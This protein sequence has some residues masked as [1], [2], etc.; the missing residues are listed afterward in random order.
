MALIAVSQLW[1]ARLPVA[2]S[3]TADLLPG[4]VL[5][6]IG[7]GLTF[8]SVGIAS[9]S[10]VRER[11]AGLASGLINTSQQVGGAVGIA[12]TSTIAA[13]HTSHL[14]RTGAAIGGALTSGFHIAFVASAAF[15]GAG[16]LIALAMVRRV[17][18]PEIQP[19]PAAETA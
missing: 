17:E 19:T 4:F 11:D 8:V 2:G 10:G 13:A 1:F 3:Y 18:A 6:P 12:I 16:A 9:L 15:A 7:L 14:L 5:L